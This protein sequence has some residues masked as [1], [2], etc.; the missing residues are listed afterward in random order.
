MDNPNPNVGALKL[1]YENTSGRPPDRGTLLDHP[2]A[3]EHIGSESELFGLEV[4]ERPASPTSLEEQ[5]MHKKGKSEVHVVN[6]ALERNST[7]PIF[8]GLEADSTLEMME[9]ED[10]CESL[11]LH[12]VVR[13]ESQGNTKISYVVVVLSES[14]TRE[15]SHSQLLEDD[16]IVTKEDVRID[17][18]G[19]IPSIV[20]LEWIHNF[21]DARMGTTEVA[22]ASEELATIGPWMVASH[23]N[24]CPRKDMSRGSDV[25]RERVTAWTSRFQVLQELEEEDESNNNL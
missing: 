14:T 19:V 17:H 18:S 22:V 6:S 1:K 3:L 11:G 9:T 25:R 8:H 23:K 12:G 5:Q 2:P 21:I 13:E 16:I 10:Q 20:F 24:R 4:L 7:R 15:K